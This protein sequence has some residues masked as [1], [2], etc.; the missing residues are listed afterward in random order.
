M[1][2]GLC[3]IRAH[4]HTRDVWEQKSPQVKLQLIIIVSDNKAS[5]KSIEAIL[6]LFIMDRKA[7]EVTDLSPSYLLEGCHLG[8][9]EASGKP[10]GSKRKE[11]SRR[12]AE[13]LPSADVP[14][15]RSC[16]G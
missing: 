10:S 13:E 15:V 2:Q 16:H 4:T 9:K 5:D 6:T 14:R 1:T 3:R 11:T 12:Q 8:R 7:K